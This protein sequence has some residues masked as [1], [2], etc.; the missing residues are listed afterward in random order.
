M[1]SRK[2]VMKKP[3][4]LCSSLRTS[5]FWF[6]IFGWLDLFSRDPTFITSRIFAH[7]F[8]LQIV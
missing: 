1:A 2:I 8:Q 4:Q 3:D 6:L 7:G 5:R